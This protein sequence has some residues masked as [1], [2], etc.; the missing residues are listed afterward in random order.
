[1]TPPRQSFV[2]HL[3]PGQGASPDD[4]SSPSPKQAGPPPQG[5]QTTP[6]GGES[7]PDP[8]EKRGTEATADHQ[9][10]A[11]CERRGA[12]EGKDGKG[13][14]AAGGEEP[15]AEG[16][17]LS[18]GSHDGAEE[19]PKEPADANNNS[20]AT[21]QN[22]REN[23]ITIPEITEEVS[24]GPRFRRVLARTRGTI[25]LLFPTG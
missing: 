7:Q 17:A 4:L 18:K 22:C 6:R 3:L 15:A 25:P 5:Q 14:R 19:E 20:M 9:R 10:T 21:P 11:G 12:E 2:D 24:G 1:M 16:P 23:F 8:A 13:E